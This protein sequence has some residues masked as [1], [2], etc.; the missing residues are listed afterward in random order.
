MVLLADQ[1]TEMVLQAV[2][3]V[4]T[5]VEVRLGRVEDRPGRLVQRRPLRP[6]CQCLARPRL[7]N[8]RGTPTTVRIP[9]EGRP[10]RDPEVRKMRMMMTIIAR[11]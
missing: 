4:V 2:V 10:A 9:Q 3:L 7:H 8:L 6:E 1:V 5:Q 11:R